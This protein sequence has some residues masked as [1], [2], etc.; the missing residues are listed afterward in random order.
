MGNK[1]AAYKEKKV[2]GLNRQI[3]ILGWVS[4]F[5]DVS[6]EMIYPLLPIFLTSVLGASA[7][8][9]GLIEG[10]AETTASLLKLFSGWISDRWQKRKALVVFGYLLSSAVRPLVAVVT[11]AGQVLI[12]R[13]LDRVGKGIRTSPR[14][15][16]I[17]DS[18]GKDVQG[19]AFGFQRAM[20][21]MGAI[22]GS[23]LS[24]LLLSYFTKD[25]RIIFALAFVPAFCAVFILILGVHEKANAPLS[26]VVTLRK[27]NLRA[28]SSSFHIFLLAV[29]IF[30]LGNSSDAFLI[31]RA[32]EKGVGVAEIPALW[33]ALH[34]VKSLSATPGGIIADRWGRKKTI[35][36]G[37]LLYSAIYWG[38]AWSKS[39]ET[40]WLLFTAY[41][42]FYGLTE[43]AE[44]ALVTDLV[45]PSLRGTAFGLYNFSIGLITLP[46]SLLMGFFWEKYGA[47]SAFIFC[48]LLAI[49]AVLVL[50]I[51]LKKEK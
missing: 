49:L 50:G 5:T 8:F 25:Y 24:F 22:I 9:L 13:F 12:I 21:H 23:L 6:S 43:G 27:I 2:W 11:S 42:L 37:W 29:I 18:T 32:Q 45:P 46:A 19:K 20:D 16:L 17:A 44:R 41:G 26:A 15:A 39:P 10:V 38:F 33:M 34:V 47:P 51:G 36:L 1:I 28:F 48:A 14:D 30:G 40:I 7:T 4:F 3:F 35:I 31:L